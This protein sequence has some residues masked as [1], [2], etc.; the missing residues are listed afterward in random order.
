MPYFIHFILYI[1][2]ICFIFLFSETSQGQP[3]VFLFKMFPGI[4]P[5][6]LICS[7]RADEIK[8]WLKMLLIR[9]QLQSARR[10]SHLRLVY[11]TIFLSYYILSTKILYQAAV[12]TKS[13]VYNDVYIFFQTLT[14][15]TKEVPY[16]KS[17]EKHLTIRFMFPPTQHF[18]L[19]QLLY[20]RTQP[21]QDFFI[22]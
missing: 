3:L 14:L 6:I 1:A 19:L 20:N 17:R 5:N 8:L 2:Y 16:S 11:F 13:C 22:C 12:D 4:F 18:F 7:L 9:V 21:S 15:K 10:L